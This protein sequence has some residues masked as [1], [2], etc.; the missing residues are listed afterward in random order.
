MPALHLSL[1]RLHLDY[2]M[3]MC[4]ICKFAQIVN[5]ANFDW[6]LQVNDH[7]TYT[8]PV[9][10]FQTMRHSLTSLH[11][12]WKGLHLQCKSKPGKYCFNVSTKA[13]ARETSISSL[14]APNVAWIPVETKSMIQGLIVDPSTVKALDSMAG[15]EA[16]K[17]AIE[18]AAYIPSQ[19]PHLLNVGYGCKN[20][21]F[22]GSPGTGK[23]TLALALAA[24]SKLPVYNVSSSHLVD[25]WLGTSEKNARALF[26]IAASNAPS[27]IIF[28]EAD[29]ICGARKS[30]SND[31]A[32]RMINEL[33]ACMTKYPKVVVIAT[34]NLPWT[35]D[36]GFVRRF[37]KNVHV[38][39]P[40]ENERREII[41][42]ALK[43]FP[44]NLSQD[45]VSEAARQADG[46]TGD[47]IQR[48]VESAA[49]VMAMKLRGVTYFQAI[50]F[51]GQKCYSPSNEG[52]IP[53]ET[54]PARHLVIPQAFVL[55]SAIQGMKSELDI[56][57]I[58]EQKHLK[59]SKHKF[60][61]T[62]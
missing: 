47:A 58:E 27:V 10:I 30:G 26:E 18:A 17:E 57:G 46:F 13:C 16:A 14:D 28:D 60:L 9:S 37:P 22:H 39:L 15:C 56:M 6:L 33:L 11:S 4:V 52:E 31:G 24:E 8:W 49:E 32:Q 34:T 19:W 55:L 2:I 45:N 21:L 51:N 20:I 7:T 1:S 36:V 3:L 29:A 54:L 42:I 44:H 53:I 35:L 38:G 25:K 23:S 62:N 50:S 61:D 41:G 43:S 48:C 59:W 40:S 12:Y 5:G